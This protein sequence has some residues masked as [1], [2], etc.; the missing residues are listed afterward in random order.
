MTAMDITVSID[1]LTFGDFEIID[2]W[3]RGNQEN[4]T[5][6]DVCD[7]MDVITPGTDVRKLK[8]SD[9]Q[10]LFDAI[11]ESIKSRDNA[12]LT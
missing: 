2:K 8:L 6:T 10:L 1:E 12:N 9:A 5:W 3:Q 7:V 4:V 11:E